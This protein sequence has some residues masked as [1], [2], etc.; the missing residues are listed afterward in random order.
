MCFMSSALHIF[1]PVQLDW[2]VG[3]GMAVLL[4]LG[5]VDTDHRVLTVYRTT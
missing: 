2:G 3:Q 1:F 4:R 5:S